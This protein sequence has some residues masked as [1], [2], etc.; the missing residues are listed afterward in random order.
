MVGSSSPQSSSTPTAPFIAQSQTPSRGALFDLGQTLGQFLVTVNNITHHVSIK[1]D[2]DNYLRWQQQFLPVFNS[3]SLMGF[4]DG[5]IKPPLK[6]S[7]TDSTT[8]TSKFTQWYALDQ[9]IQNWIVAI[10]FNAAIGQK[11]GLTSASAM[12]LKLQRVYASTSQAYLNHLRFTL[13]TLRKGTMTMSAYLENVKHIIGNLTVV[14]APLEDWTVTHFVVNG[15]GLDFEPFAQTVTGQVEPHFDN[16]SRLSLNVVARGSRGSGRGG[17]GRASLGC[18]QTN[19]NG[20]GYGHSQTDRGNSS[21]RPLGQMCKK[22]GHSAIQCH[23]RFNLSYQPSPTPQAH[24]MQV[25]NQAD[26]AWYIV[27]GASHHITSDPSLLTDNGSCT[28]PDQVMHGNGSGLPISAIGTCH[29]TQS[30]PL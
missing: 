18:G 4:V 6:Y 5:S 30:L 23:N 27:S 3:Q 15:L 12:W 8:V 10:L 11:I 9:T 2:R 22:R 25:D 19:Q 29:L 20:R 24:S 7:A 14:G 26:V 28:G 21:N 1:L 17:R 16:S 13:Q